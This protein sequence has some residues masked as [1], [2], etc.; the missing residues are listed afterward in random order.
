MGSII[1]CHRTKAKHPYEITRIHRQIH[2][3]EELCYYLC[4]YLYLVDYTIINEKL[5][6]WLSAELQLGELAEE[7]RQNLR[8]SGSQEQ[9]VM[10]ILANS[11]IY[12]LAEL[13]HM[14]EVLA[15]LKNQ[16]P[17]EKQKYKADSL[18]ETGG[19]RQAI[20]VYQA[21]LRE[22]VDESVDKKFYGKVYACLGSA[23]GRLFLYKEAARMYEAAYQICEDRGMLKGYLYACSQYMEPIVYQALLQKNSLYQQVQLEIAQMK[24]EVKESIKNYPNQDMLQEWKDE[25]RK[26]G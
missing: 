10:T 1:L 18:L 21:I 22:E 23:Y 26:K 15:R 25:Y 12:S 9:F 5:C 16:R 14:Q 24:Q 17:I 8:Q 20:G 4:N 11:G 3:M 13:K 2:S 7:L 19:I 6:E